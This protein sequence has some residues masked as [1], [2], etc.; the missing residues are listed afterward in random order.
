MRVSAHMRREVFMSRLLLVVTVGAVLSCGGGHLAGQQPADGGQSRAS[1]SFV[2][3]PVVSGTVT[4]YS[5]DST[6]TRTTVLATATTD[7]NGGFYLQLAAPSTGPVLLVVSSGSYTEPATGTAISLQGSELTTLLPSA[8]HVAGDSLD[9][10]L[11]S[12]VSHLTARLATWYVASA[13]LSVDAALTQAARLLESHFGAVSWRTFGVPPDLTAASSS[14]LVQVND[15]AKGA[16]ILAGLS[17]EARNL[18]VAKGLSPGGP[19]NSLTLLSALGEDL[20]ADGFFD[21]M[22][23]GGQRIQ[24]PAGLNGYLLD[25]QTVRASLA[26]G[27]TTFL[28]NPRNVSQIAAADAQGLVT[29]IGTDSNTQ[30]FRNGSGNVDLVPPSIQFVQPGS[31]ASVH[32]SVTVEAV[33]TDNVAMGSFSFTAPVS[34][35]GVQSSTENNGAS[36]HLLATLDVSALPDGP[37]TI[38][39]QATDTSSNTAAQS[40]LVHVANHGP[41]ITV[42]S[43]NAGAVAKGTVTI[44]AS[45]ASQ[46][47][48]AITILEIKGTL[49]GAGAD[50]LPAAEQLQVSW[51]TTQMLEGPGQLTLHAEDASGAASDL[52]VNVTVDNVPFGIFDAYVSAGAPIAG[53][54]VKVIAVDLSTGLINPT[55]GVN[56]V[57][58]AGGPTDQSGFYRLTLNTENYRGPVQVIASGTNLTYVDP[59]DGTTIISIPNSAALTSLLGDYTTGQEV[60]LPLDLW[61]SLADAEAI[62]YTQGLNRGFPV[63]HDLT[64]AL[65]FGDPLFTSH[66]TSSLWNIRTTLPTSLTTAQQTLADV[67]YA[68][69]PDIALNRLARDLAKKGNL[70]PGSVSAFDLLALLQKD[71]AADGQFDGQGAAGTQLQTVGHPAQ[72]LDANTL[73]FYLAY[74]LDEFVQGPTNKTTLGRP[75]FQNAGIYDTISNDT[76][77]LFGAETPLAFD[78]TP[79]T[80]SFTATFQP[81]AGG[82]AQAPVGANNLVSGTLALTVSASDPSGVASLSLSQNGIAITPALGSS[83]PTKIVYSIDTTTLVDGALTFIAASADTFVNSGHTT[84]TV[85]VANAP[86]SISFAPAQSGQAGNFVANGYY[87]SSVP[88]DASAIDPNGIASFT[89]SGLAGFND[90]DGTISRIAGTWAVPEG[91]SD[92]PVSVSFATC[93]VVFVCNSTTRLFYVDRTPPTVSLVSA[94]PQYTAIAALILQVSAADTGSGVA[95]VYAQNGNGTVVSATASSNGAY[96]LSVGLNSGTNLIAIWA[97]DNVG[98]SGQ[99]KASPEQASVSIILDVAGPSVGSPDITVS[100]YY[101]ETGIALQMADAGVP[102]MPAQY[103]YAGGFISAPSGTIHKVSTRLGWGEQGLS[104]PAVSELTGANPNNYPFYYLN[105]SALS[106]VASASFSVTIAQTNATSSGTLW[107]VDATHFVLPLTSDTIPGLLSLPA[108]LTP[109]TLQISI[110]ATSGSGVTPAAVNFTQSFTVLGAPLAWAEDAAIKSSSFDGS[111]TYQH[112]LSDGAYSSMFP[113]ATSVKLIRYV[114]RNPALVPVAFRVSGSGSWAANET[115]ADGVAPLPT[116]LGF[117]SY[118]AP[119]GSTLSNPLTVD[120][121][122]GAQSCGYGMTYSCTS[123]QYALHS[124]ATDPRTLFVCGS[125]PVPTSALLAAENDAT[126]VISF[127][128]FGNPQVNG[129]ETAA[130][131]LTGDGYYVVPQAANGQPGSVVVYVARPGAVTR[132][133]QL[134][135]QDIHSNTGNSP[136]FEQWLAD[137]WPTKTGSSIC[138]PDSQGN[139]YP[140]Y[141][142]ATQREVKYLSAAEDIVFGSVSFTT[143]GLNAGATSSIGTTTVIASG[144]NFTRSISH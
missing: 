123:Q 16:L 112:P 18:A 44:S 132:Q 119:D 143:A 120:G 125:R 98:N 36:M 116:N 65:A 106:G 24:V 81:T 83:L 6:A 8:V 68:A 129:G 130:P 100:K 58:G 42:T 34:L 93:N 35:I 53:A 43:P 40:L 88:V 141:E 29:E 124:P 50:Q 46:T 25:G 14:G 114:L 63:A 90:L 22:G 99:G 92:G 102:I 47:G 131:S 15:L 91:L 9:G 111:S 126:S 60:A 115:W 64:D 11:I 51:D 133:T 139:S 69:V 82:S 117:N 56:G 41:V 33:A 27:I 26:Q 57:M 13:H 73:R 3:W 49:P 30:L 86:P 85:I 23:A 76:S 62:A 54:N 96:A 21:G 78:D 20:S 138:G 77:A 48:S 137:L 122:G 38:S 108:S 17:Q 109:Y 140:Y 72:S 118:T 95:A 2:A 4:A 55:V 75:D 135:Y 7:V 104:Q 127:P 89:M 121:F 12:P 113:E 134:D 87:A 142:Y 79:P 31:N 66:I 105:I 80:V 84:F 71:L 39:A 61:T 136:R 101:D 144:I 128:A 19:I 45:A 107:P 1:T 5:V 32:G 74:A 110:T 28:T 97:A 59:S 52:I 37:L 10:V 70:D 103:S 67:V 94:P